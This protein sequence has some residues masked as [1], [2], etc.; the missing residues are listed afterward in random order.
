V[1]KIK[2][3]DYTAPWCGPCKAMEPVLEA[4]KIELADK[5]EFEVIN[6]ETEPEKA[7][8]AGVMSVPT[9]HIIVDDKITQTLIG[10]QAKD[11]MIKH[12]QAAL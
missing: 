6:V 11:E 4:I 3:I 5:I 12:L 8:A 7:S 2:L 10:Y 1:A 9:F